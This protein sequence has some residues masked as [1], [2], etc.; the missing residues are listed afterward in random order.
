MMYKNVVVYC[1]SRFG[2]NP[3]YASF[4]GQL[5][6][7]LGRGGF[8]MVYGGGTVG[9]MGICAD[10]AMAAGGTVT[11]VIP[12]VF[13]AKEQAHRG[14]TEL[15]EVP[16]M[17]VR[18]RKMLELGDAFV[19]LPGGFG[20]LEELAETANHYHIYGDPAH[21]PPIIIV[22]IEGIYDG[23]LRQLTAWGEEEFADMEEWKNIHVCQSLGEVMGILRGTAEVS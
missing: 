8:H 9:L 3:A 18:K 10:A 2:V 13:I 4:A 5:G 6:E 17:T 19:V 12:E 16:D 14:L 1:G 11:G 23:L 21:Q 20:T 7:A 22:N 15:L